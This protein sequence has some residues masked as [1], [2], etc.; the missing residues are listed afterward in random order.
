ME[1]G[2]KVLFISA[3]VGAGHV[4]AAHAVG[5][6]LTRL[7]PAIRA[8]YANVFDFFSPWLGRTIL[9]VYLKILDIFPQ[10]Y[11]A[12]YS[13]GNTSRL[14]RFGQGII[15]GY[16]AGRMAQYLAASRPD[17]IVVTHAT[18][19][20][21]VAYLARQGRLGAP[22]VAVVTDFVVH[23][24]WVNP[25]LDE[26]VVAHG[27]LRDYLADNGVPHE[28]SVA[29]G[30]PVDDKFTAP[31]TR[32]EAAARLGLAAGRPTVLVMGGGAGVMPMAEIVAALD[33]L[34]LPLNIVTVAGKNAA[35]QE[36]LA[37]LTGRLRHAALTSLG[38]VDNVHELMAAADLLVS[39]PGGM[40]AAEALARGL[41]M[42]IY[43]PI[44]G[45]EEA[46]TRF[47]T[48][49]GAARRLESAAE[50]AAAVAGLL[51]PN[52][53]ELAAMRAAALAL[54][55]PGAAEAIAGRLLARLSK[56]DLD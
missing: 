17:A 51:A 1:K 37:A 45:Q 5:A 8:E 6:A 49:H 11:G 7:A 50:L 31:L 40:T 10:A 29:L 14:A 13:W 32:E 54:G 48:A 4:R 36:R 35:L 52:S 56:S 19:G 9:G 25:E 22:A 44:P 23:R 47:L 21:L 38:F 34:A 3:P 15:S 33:D 42:L 2:Y 18:P 39:K 12:A 53:G 41:P 26:Y 24:L 27:A 16:L 20:G 55:R 46:N 43:R 30:I 28:R